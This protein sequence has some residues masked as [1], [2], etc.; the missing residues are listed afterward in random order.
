MPIFIYLFRTMF[1]AVLGTAFLGRALS[2]QPGAQRATSIQP[3]ESCPPGMT[4]IRPR[5]CMAP[6]EAAPSILD[7]RPRSTLVASTHLVKKARYPAIDF[8]G[9]PQG[10]LG[11]V[12]SLARRGADLDSLNVRMMI[13]ANNVSGDALKRMVATINTSPSMKAR[14]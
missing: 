5:S 7:Y 9:H 14:V 4:E 3:G 1:L 8:H 13:V 6:E 10:M 11:S 12:A 2:A